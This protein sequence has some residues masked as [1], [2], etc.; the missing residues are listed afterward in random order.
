MSIYKVTVPVEELAEGMVLAKTFN[1]KKSEGVDLLFSWAG[2]KLT[3][4]HIEKL[5]LHKVEE[6]V[7]FTDTPPLKPKDLKFGRQPK[8]TAASTA[9][10][11]ASKRFN[12]ALPKVEPTIKDD[13]RDETIETLRTLFD[14]TR[15]S[16]DYSSNNLTTAYQNIK[17]LDTTV[18]RLISALTLRTNE[19]VHINN[20]KSYDEYTYHH[21]LSVAVLS[22]AI[23]QALGLDAAALKRLCHCAILHDIGKIF[24]PIELISKTG[25]L[26]SQEFEIVKTHAQNG[27]QYLKN[28]NIG[29]TD[30]W[31]GV[32]YHHEKVDGSGYPKKLKKNEIPLFSRIISVADVYDAITSYRPY[33]IP[34]VPGDA[35]EM[36]MS[37]AGSAFDFD[38]VDALSRKLDLYPLNTVVMLSNKRYGIITDN[39][40]VKRPLVRML[41]TGEIVDLSKINNMNLIIVKVQNDSI[42][43]TGT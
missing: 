6:V 19:F 20:I 36:I 31:L 22:V 28:G 5:R 16:L 40:N 29:N 35:L 4:W 23:G 14:A 30:L 1:I 2:A 9:I 7:V 42:E 34:M 38:V 43:E 24:L 18:Y 8:R 39:T 41:D 25:R 15:N 17:E 32:I 27:G 21:S 10:K 33:R 3:N 37:A 12:E 13:L 11:R 26:G